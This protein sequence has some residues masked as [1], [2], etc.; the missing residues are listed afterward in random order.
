MT[1]DDD[2]RFAIDLSHQAGA[3]LMRHYEKLDVREIGRK[4]TFRDLVT[5]ADTESERLIVDAIR[6]R[7]PDHTIYAEETSHHFSEDGPTW[8]VDPLDGTI[9]FVHSLPVFG[10]SIALYDGRTPRLAAIHLPVLQETYWASAGGGAYRDGHGIHVSQTELL[11][12]ALVATGFPYA[13]NTL[14]HNNLANFN[15]LFY[16]V[17][18][19]RRIGACCADLAWVASGRLDAFWELHLGPYDLAAG[20]LLIREAGGVVTDAHG[21]E[22]W[23]REGHLVAGPPA[24]HANLLAKVAHGPEPNA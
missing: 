12:E 1:T 8:Y 10:V 2:L 18:G 24:L 20:A 5:R 9:N 7:F 22:N 21:G 13:R 14:V 16:E 3:V 15:R 23:L 11:S 4:S 6:G 17:R 19:L